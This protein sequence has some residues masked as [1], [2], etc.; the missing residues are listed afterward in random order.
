[1]PETA[2][3]CVR[4]GLKNS[5]RGQLNDE[6]MYV[7]VNISKKFNFSSVS[8]LARNAFCVMATSERM[9]CVAGH[10]ESSKRIKL[11]SSSVNVINFFKKA[12]KAKRSAHN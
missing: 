10:V 8:D 5:L 7:Q 6:P 11:K 9:L 3:L 1:V 12:L 2:K 4:G